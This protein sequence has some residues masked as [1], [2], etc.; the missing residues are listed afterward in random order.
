MLLFLDLDGVVHPHVNYSQ[1]TLFVRRSMLEDVLRAC[2][3]VEV[4][5][6]STWRTTRTLL[7]L[8]S[9]FSADIGARI[10]DKTPLWQDLQDEATYG[11]YVRQAE[12][13]AWLRSADRAWESWVA[14]DDQAGLFRPFCKKLIL[15]NSETGLTADDCVTLAQRLSA[16]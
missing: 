16:H 2:P 7:E 3:N 1:E 6:S 11:T 15:T 4:V 13:E 12:I 8:Q 10:I 5:I 14:L 9:L